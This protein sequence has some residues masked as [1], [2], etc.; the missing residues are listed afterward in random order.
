MYSMYGDVI[1]AEVEENEKLV[2]VEYDAKE[3]IEVIYDQIEGVV[4]YANNAN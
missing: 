1:E 4:E 2:K 3:E